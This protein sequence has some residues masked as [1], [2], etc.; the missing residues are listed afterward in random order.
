ML[1]RDV[2]S[3]VIRIFENM[4]CMGKGGKTEKYS[5]IKVF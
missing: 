1:G 4:R 5:R 2:T 3:A